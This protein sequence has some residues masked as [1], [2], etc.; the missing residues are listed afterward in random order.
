MKKKTVIG[1]AFAAGAAAA[2][3]LTTYA[4][5]NHLLEIAIRRDGKLSD[6]TGGRNVMGKGWEHFHDKI[7]A[8]EEWYYKCPCSVLEIYSE[9]ALRLNGKFYE[10]GM[11]DV[12]SQDE[13]NE[14]DEGKGVVIM[15]HGYRSNTRRDLAFTAM[16]LYEAGYDILLIDNRAHNQSQGKYITLG[17]K[18]ARDIVCWVN[19]VKALKGGKPIF[20][21]GLSMGATAVMLSLED[22]DI[23]GKISGIIA[24]CGFTSPGVMVKDLLK[25]SFHLP[26]KPF[27]SVANALFKKKTGCTFDK[28]TVEVLG[29]SKVPALFIHGEKD[30]FVS[31][32]MSRENYEASAADGEK[33]KLLIVPGATHGQSVYR[34]TEAVI[35]S[36]CSFMEE[37]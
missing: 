12:D 5:A 27:Y 30:S 35:G 9:D 25:T 8:G 7:T 31:Y 32:N 6:I 17:Q 36:I 19:H 1:A 18:E 21:Y 33:K 37:V 3:G 34:D 13:F 15:V 23:S 22:K 26:E 16:K 24:D 11:A 4:T 29:R 20:L 10:H 14:Y 2:L 28:S